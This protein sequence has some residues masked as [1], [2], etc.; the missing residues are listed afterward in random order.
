MGYQP[1][2]KV[3]ADNPFRDLDYSGYHKNRI[4]KEL[5]SSMY[6]NLGYC[7]FNTIV[8][9]VQLIGLIICSNY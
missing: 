3:E 4:R 5:E 8:T 9:F 7:V 1:K 6:N 2:P